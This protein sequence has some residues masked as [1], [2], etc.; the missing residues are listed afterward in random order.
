MKDGEP[1]FVAKDCAEI[2]GYS[3][4]RKAVE[5]HCKGGAKHSLPT[6]GGP[7]QMTIIPERD[8]YRLVMRS[9]LPSAARFEEWVVG[10]V[11]PAIRKTGSYSAPAPVNAVN[12][13]TVPATTPR[14]PDGGED[15]GSHPPLECHRLGFPA[16]QD[17][18]V[19]AGFVNDGHLL[20]SSSG[21][22]IAYPLFILVE[23]AHRDTRICVPQHPADFGRDEPGLSALLDHV[24]AVVPEVEDATT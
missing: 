7:Q 6:A 1:W 23:P 21:I 15:L 13:P 11:L 24:D 19:Q 12:T 18:G 16:G 14:L 5:L 3:T 20:R 2:L 17:E 10:E 9:K 8:V 4:A 22:N